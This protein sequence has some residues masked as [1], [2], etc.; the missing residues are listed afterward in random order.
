MTP[1]PEPTEI[2]VDDDPDARPPRTVPAGA[3]VVAVMVAAALGILVVVALA[4]DGGAGTGDGD[5]DDVRAAAGRFA[6]RF[7]TFEHDAIDEWKADVLDAST[8]GFAEEVDD[9]EAGLRRLISEAELDA[10]AEVTDI[11][12]GDIDRGTVSVVLLYDREVRGTSGPRREVDRYMQL[13]L[14]EVD[15]EWLVDEVIDIAT[16]GGLGSEGPA[17]PAPSTSPETTAAPTSE[18]AG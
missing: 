16:A 8:G 3:F 18:P 4:I 17:D 6:E 14:I 5:L 11:Y 9:V 13:T 10:S 2:P 15:G 12:V 7:L 1:D